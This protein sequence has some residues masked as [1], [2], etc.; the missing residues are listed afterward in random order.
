VGGAR[1]LKGDVAGSGGN[2]DIPIADLFDAALVTDAEID[3]CRPTQTGGHAHDK[4]VVL[5]MHGALVAASRRWDVFA[6]AQTVLRC[7]LKKGLTHD[8]SQR[9]SARQIADSFGKRD[10]FAEARS[11]LIAAEQML[12]DGFLFGTCQRG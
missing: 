1:L 2:G 4:K 7:A 10:H 12:L 5:G 8:H 9:S 3:S 6:D 11:T